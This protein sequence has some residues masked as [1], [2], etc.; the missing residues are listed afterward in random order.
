MVRYTDLDGEEWVIE[1]DGLL[2]R[3]LQHE[4]DHLDGKTLFES[5]IFPPESRHSTIT[6]KRKPPVRSPAIPA[7][8]VDCARTL[9]RIAR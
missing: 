1:G 9:L 2:G 6:K 5:S 3:C 8:S 4:I 7:F